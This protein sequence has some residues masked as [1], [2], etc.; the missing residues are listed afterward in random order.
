MTSS[1]TP[2]LIAGAGPSGLVLALTLAQNK[3]PVRIIEKELSPRLGQRGAGL[4][5][6]SLEL[7]HFFGIL[8]DIQKRGFPT[9]KMRAYK[10]PEGV[11]PVQTYDLM[12]EAWKPT[13]DIPY[14]NGLILGQSTY[15]GIIREHL[16]RAGVQVEFGTE[17]ISFV[18][19]ESGVTATVVRHGDNDHTELIHADWLVCADGGRSNARKALGLAFLGE[20]QDA[21]R[22][23]ITDAEVKG[24]SPEYWHSWGNLGSTCFMLRATEDPAIFNSVITGPPHLLERAQEGL[25]GFA[26]VMRT[27]TNRKDLDVKRVVWQSEWRP[28]VRIVENYRKGRIFLV[29]DAAHVHTPAGGQGAN[30][31]MQD[32]MNL[33]WKLA[34]VHHAV[35]N[36]SLLDTYNEERHPVAKEMLVRTSKTF[37]EMFKKGGASGDIDSKEN[38]GGGPVQINMS[39]IFKQLRVNYRWSSIVV[40][41]LHPTDTDRP[42]E[43]PAYLSDEDKELCAGDRAPDAPGLRILSANAKEDSGKGMKSLFDIFAPT[44][45]TLLLFTGSENPHAY[46]KEVETALST[47]R[48]AKETF[49]VVVILSSSAPHGVDVQVEGLTALVVLDAEDH[50][51][52]AYQVDVRTATV[53]V[54]RPDGVVGAVLQPG[55]EGVESGLKRYLEGVFRG[56]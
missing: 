18:Q 20:T 50:A 34:L 13:P 14:P 28:N 33:G 17:L 7:F 48:R 51:H 37:N 10:M 53:V 54:V 29:G 41:Q 22:V 8:P 30:T 36:P 40:D 3:V 12:G 16:A 27:I 52:T 38:E 6:R 21:L 23:L 19:D 4:Q 42:G 5:P 46:L 25:E 15:E 49:R 9:P 1:K 32:A 2:V 56:V 39:T 55:E 47:F 11:D 43:A 31:G 44:R 35:A 26:E 45:H 24:A